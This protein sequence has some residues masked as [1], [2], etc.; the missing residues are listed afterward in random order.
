M[1]TRSPFFTFFTSLPTSRTI[2]AASCPSIQSPPTTKLPIV[3]RFQ[4]WISDLCSFHQR[5]MFKLERMRMYPQIP[6]TLICS[7]T[8]FGPGFKIGAAAILMVW[9][10][11][12]CRLGFSA[13]TISAAVEDTASISVTQH[14]GVLASFVPF[15]CIAGSVVGAM[16]STCDG[17][18]FV[19]WYLMLRGERGV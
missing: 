15:S 4:K 3:P 17:A 10:L 18:I 9:S 13:C 1:A 7:N 2:P 16:I 5:R 12:T 11:V 8:S 6:V 19:V 14:D